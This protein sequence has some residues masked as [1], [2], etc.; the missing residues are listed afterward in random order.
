MLCVSLVTFVHVP[1]SD[2]IL[3]NFLFGNLRRMNILYCL[4]RSFSKDILAAPVLFFGQEFEPS[5]GG[6]TAF[7]GVDEHCLSMKWIDDEPKC[8]RGPLLSLLAILVLG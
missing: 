8:F 4:W 7:S 2:S 5:F 3:V 1:G 6:H